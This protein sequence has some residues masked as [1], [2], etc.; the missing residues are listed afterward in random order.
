V[1]VSIQAVSPESILE[2][3]ASSATAKGADSANNKS[4]HRGFNNFFIFSIIR[5]VKDTFVPQ[6]LLIAMSMPTFGLLAKKEI[7][8]TQPRKSGLVKM[9]I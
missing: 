1:A 7:E 4:A 3:P 6:Y 8:L 2:A 5:V 9:K